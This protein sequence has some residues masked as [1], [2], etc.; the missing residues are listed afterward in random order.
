MVLLLQQELKDELKLLG[1]STTGV[2]AE[3]AQ[4]LEEA[5]SGS[6]GQAAP[7]SEPA[8]ASAATTAGVPASDTAAKVIML[9][10]FIWCARGTRLLAC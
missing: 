2:K 3:L 5:I 1:L 4:R 7:A 10:E 9:L 6:S 8:A